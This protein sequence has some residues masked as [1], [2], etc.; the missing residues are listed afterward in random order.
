MIWEPAAEDRPSPPPRRSKR[1]ERRGRWLAGSH[2]LGWHAGRVLGLHRIRKRHVLLAA[3]GA[4]V[5]A[6]A[7]WERCGVAGCP[8]VTRLVAYQPG[9]APALL[10]RNGVEFATLAPF[11]RDVVPLA[12]LPAHVGQ[13][14][15]AVEDR[16]FD[17]HRGVDWL[18]VIGAAVA[19][20]RAGGIVQGSSTLTMQLARNVFPEQVPGTEKSLRRKL[21]EVRVARD[22]E[23]RFSKE[24]IL[25]LYLNHI[26]FGGGAY[27]IEAAAHY[28]F[29]RTASELTLAQ[30]ALLAALPKAPAHY[31]PRR[32][33]EAARARRD[34]VLSLMAEQER[35][36]AAALAEARAAEIAVSEA[37]PFGGNQPGVAPYFKDAV[38]RELEDRFG[39][40]LYTS[41]LTI[42]TTL[43]VTAQKAAEEELGRQLRRIEQGTYGRFNGPRYEAEAGAAA[44]SEHLEGA[45]VM[46]DVATGDVRAL[47]GGRD[48]RASRFDR[49]VRGQRQAGSAFKPFVYATALMEG[50]PASQLVAD[51][52]LRVSLGGGRVWEP[53]NYDGGFRGM[54]SM[55]EALA[56]S[57]NVP[58]VRVAEAVGEADVARTAHAAGLDGDI[59]EHPSMALGTASVSPLVL[60]S[61]YTA[62][63]GLGRAVTPR[64]VRRVEDANGEIVWQEEVDATDA[65]DPAVAYILT[66]MLRDAVD[67][68]TGNAVRQVGFHGLAAGKTGTTSDGH[69]AWFVGYTPELVGAVWIGFDQPRPILRTATGGGL[70]A[71]VWGRIARRFYDGRTAPDAWPMPP[72]V[73]QRMVDIDTGRPL[74][75]GCQ[76]RYGE[77]RMELFLTSMPVEEVCPRRGFDPGRWIGGILDRLGIGRDD[78][79]RGRRDDER[80]RGRRDDEGE[81]AR[82]D[83]QRDIDEAIR[84]LEQILQGRRGRDARIESD[85]ARRDEDW[86]R[87]RRQQRDRDR[88]GGG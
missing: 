9:G 86:I 72:G 27:G 37:A 80:V 55:R 25:E 21:L 6:A 10:D 35:A 7:A 14:F 16:R 50:L 66:D 78:H 59:P 88:R 46:L 62:F 36:P 31:D 34:L 47:V 79:D 19:N 51:E 38:R 82:R 71:P 61:A 44:G 73:V 53:R 4:A 12:Q 29:D 58:A 42:H 68:G 39:E 15:L 18:R 8:D 74:A 28:Y 11:R 54:M 75:E 48:Y 85:R 84:E 70:A 69:D 52:P 32:H 81:R 83:A 23:A 63:A 43:D 2:R 24:E 49:A 1:S 5:L 13:A 67:R 30:A 22:I 20:V 77:Q 64:F 33:P 17:R 60:A 76:P 3:A 87:E 40:R 57:R 56:F 45:V 65:I 41:R 26:Y